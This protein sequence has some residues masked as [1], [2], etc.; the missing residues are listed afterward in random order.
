VVLGTYALLVGTH[1]G[2]FFPFSL[3]AMFSSGGRPWVR[4]T[5]RELKGETA[6]LSCASVPAEALPGE[7]FPIRTVGLDQNDLSKFLLPLA[8]DPVAADLVLLERMFD[9]PRRTRELVIYRARGAR[10]ANGSIQ[11]RYRALAAVGPSGTRTV[12]GCVQ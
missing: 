12:A 5:V 8:I 7:P 1:K 2:E 6:E 4:A 3:F 10:E 11:V 9:V